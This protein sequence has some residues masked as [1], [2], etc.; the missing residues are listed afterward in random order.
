[1]ILTKYSQKDYAGRY[2]LKKAEKQLI[3]QGLTKTNE[4]LKL[5]VLLNMEELDL[6]GAIVRHGITVS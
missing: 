5:S 6:L 2:N 1:M 3:L 4:S